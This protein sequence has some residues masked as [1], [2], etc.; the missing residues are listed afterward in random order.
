MVEPG[1]DGEHA[2]TRTT[3]AIND[4]AMAGRI[5]R[6]STSRAIRRRAAA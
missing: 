1:L 5:A 6:L 2:P 3:S 4:I